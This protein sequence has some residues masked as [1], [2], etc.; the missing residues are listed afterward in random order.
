VWAGAA[1]VV[2]STIGNSTTLAFGVIFYRRVDWPEVTLSAD[3]LSVDAGDQAAFQAT[4]TVSP[5]APYGLH[6]GVIVVTDTGRVDVDATYRPHKTIIPLTWQVWPAPSTGFTPG[7]TLPA[8]TPYEDGWIGGGFGWKVKES[9]DWRFYGFDLRGP[10][11]GSVILVHTVWE[12]P[13][14]DVDT[15]ILGPTADAFSTADPV[16]F[17]PHGLEWVGGTTRAGSAGAWEFSTATGGAEDWATAPAQ[18]GLYVLAQQAVLF[19]GHQN[20]VPF[21]TTVTLFTRTHYLPLV[22]RGGE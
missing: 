11:R 1:H 4:V 10:P 5:T 22:L 6:Q 13:P 17:G 18:D 16:W 14:T 12:D 8:G 15:L 19:G 7:G 9:G 21:T 3:S 20:A 2:T